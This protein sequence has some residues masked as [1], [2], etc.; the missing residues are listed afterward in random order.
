MMRYAQ[1]IPTRDYRK[2][3]ERIAIEV[4]STS[5]ILRGNV[6]RAD[7]EGIALAA[8][9]WQRNFDLTLRLREG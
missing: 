8:K 4:I 9:T 7:L 5:G 3:D 2:M 6:R 1:E